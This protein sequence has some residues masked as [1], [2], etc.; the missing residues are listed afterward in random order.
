MDREDVRL[1]EQLA[2]EF[3]GFLGALNKIGTPEGKP[4]PPE[5]AEFVQ[6]MNETGAKIKARREQNDT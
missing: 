3:L 6:R 4:E 5:V 2:G 1:Q